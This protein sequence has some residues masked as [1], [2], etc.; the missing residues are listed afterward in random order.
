MARVQGVTPRPRSKSLQH[1]KKA[2]PAG[3]AFQRT[4]CQMSRE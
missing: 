4:G 1:S 3:A 2:A